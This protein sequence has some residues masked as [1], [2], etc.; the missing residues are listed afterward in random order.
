MPIIAANVGVIAGV[1]AAVVV[2]VVVLV[3]VMRKKG[4]ASQAPASPRPAEQPTSVSAPNNMPSMVAPVRPEPVAPAPS[5]AM[6]V[7]AAPAPSAAPLE[8]EPRVVSTSG[9]VIQVP[10]ELP[11]GEPSNQD[12]APLE[13]AA[14]A[15]VPML[16]E[17]ALEPSLED[18]SMGTDELPRVGTSEMAAVGASGDAP[19]Y[20]TPAAQDLQR[21]I[22]SMKCPKCSQPTFVGRETPEELGT[23]G[24]GMF[25]LEGR[26]GACGHKAQVMDMRIG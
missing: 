4:G 25:K 21:A 10:T 23:D 1:V 14:T 16:A 12:L 19:R 26:C 11:A 8:G 9:R 22:E 6:T 15:E 17:A 24:V 20:R 2:V 5:T 3:L 7:P 18:P 13:P